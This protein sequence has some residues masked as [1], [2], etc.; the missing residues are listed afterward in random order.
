MPNHPNIAFLVVG[1]QMLLEQARVGNA[2]VAGEEDEVA[3][4]LANAQVAGRGGATIILAE[5]A[6]AGLGDTKASYDL[7]GGI[8]RT[9]VHHHDLIVGRRQ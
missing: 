5:V 7:R 2:V 8:G 9:V 1:A 4:R 3:A 6:K